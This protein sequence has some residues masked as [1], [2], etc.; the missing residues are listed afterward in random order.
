MKYKLLIMIM[1][2]KAGLSYGTSFQYI[3]QRDQ[4]FFLFEHG[5][6][7]VPESKLRSKATGMIK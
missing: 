3:T 5:S 4:R 6:T 7:S 2:K 1:K